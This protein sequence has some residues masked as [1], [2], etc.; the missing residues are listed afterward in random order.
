MIGTFARASALAIATVV[1]VSPAPTLAQKQRPPK[2]SKNVQ[3]LLIQ[4][5]EAQEKND[6]ATARQLLT[7]AEGLASTDDDKYMVNALL[8]NSGVATQDN[9]LIEKALEGALASGKVP[10]EEEPKFIRNLGALALQRNDLT[11][12]TA[13]FERL[14][15]M[16][17]ND[18]SIMIDVAEL[19]RRQNQPAKAVQTINTAISTHEQA[20]GGKADEQWYRRALGIAYDAKLP[21]ETNAASQAL[22]TAYPNPTNWRDVLVIYRDS[23]KF[24]DQMNL[25]IMRLMRANKALTGE[26]DYAEFAEIASHRGFPGEAKAILDEGI[27]AG[28]LQADRPFVKELSAV[29][30]P[31]IAADRKSLPTLEKEAATAKTGRAALGTADAYLGY[32]EYAKAAELYKLALQKGGVDND[33]ANVRLGFALGKTGDKAGAEAALKAVA[34]SPR[35]SL[36][37]YWLIWLSQQA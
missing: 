14:L 11:K 20:S 28:A 29:V 24:D 15:Q 17:P 18:T 5:Q 36:A 33:T 9:A 19:Q 6:H 13:Q 27:A 4:A 23:G 3:P 25:D 32:G 37:E 22:V 34:G 10:A 8:L 31:K 2:L 26:R 7:Q 21:A 12:A 30:S 16:T 35:K 1:L